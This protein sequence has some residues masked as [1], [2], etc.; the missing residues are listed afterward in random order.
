MAISARLLL[1]LLLLLFERCV[2]VFLHIKRIDVLAFTNSR[3]G[4]RY[5]PAYA[6]VTHRSSCS[7][8]NSPSLNTNTLARRD[9]ILIGRQEKE[10]PLRQEFTK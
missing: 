8:D 1:P 4:K 9:C 10:F 7:A 3:T 5:R 6:M 2:I